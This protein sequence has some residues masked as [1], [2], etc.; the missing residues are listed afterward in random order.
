MRIFAGMNE[1]SDIQRRLARL[2]RR[3]E[4]T[5]SDRAVIILSIA[6]ILHIIASWLL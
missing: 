5:R 6:I 2:E 1:Y 3:V 4:Q